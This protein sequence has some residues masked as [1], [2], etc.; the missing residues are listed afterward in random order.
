[1]LA[2]LKYPL[3]LLGDCDRCSWS[4]WQ[5][6]DGLLSLCAATLVFR[7]LLITWRRQ[8]TMKVPRVGKCQTD[9]LPASIDLPR[10]EGKQERTRSREGVK[11]TRYTVLRDKDGTVWEPFCRARLALHLTFVINAVAMGL[12]RIRERFQDSSHAIL[13]QNGMSYA[14]CIEP[15]TGRLPAVVEVTKVNSQVSNCDIGHLAVL[16]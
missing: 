13:P 10:I 6:A 16:P 5:F 15:S 9:N 7:I 1:M 2:F 12:C 3:D 4:D 11:V 14:V 8:E